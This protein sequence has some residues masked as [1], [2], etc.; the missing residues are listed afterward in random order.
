MLETKRMSLLVFVRNPACEYQV[1]NS[2]KSLNKLNI[3]YHLRLFE[4]TNMG[5]FNWDQLGSNAEFFT[6]SYNISFCDNQMEKIN[7]MPRK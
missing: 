7:Q 2:K 3:F 6:F 4:L 1:N 5:S